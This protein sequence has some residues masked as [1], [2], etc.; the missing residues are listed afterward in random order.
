M[1]R[2]AISSRRTRPFVRYKTEGAKLVIAAYGITGRIAKAAVN[3]ARAQGMK[4]G[5]VRPKAVWPF[6]KKTFLKAAATA[7]KFLAVEMSNGQFI[8]DVELAI[9][10]SKPVEFFGCGGGW[11]P[12]GENIFEKI[13]EVY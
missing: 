10:C 7:E 4:V 11:Y 5:L 12:T 1:R 2:A 8:E 6:P 3:A 13:K 9:R